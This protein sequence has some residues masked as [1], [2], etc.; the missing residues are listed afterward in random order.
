M[1][2]KMD[3]AVPYHMAWKTLLAPSEAGPEEQRLCRGHRSRM[4]TQ[5]PIL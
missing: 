1:A 2:N 3:A 5:R 4:V